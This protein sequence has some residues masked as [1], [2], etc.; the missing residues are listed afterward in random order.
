MALAN[1]AREGMEHAAYEHV[2]LAPEL[3]GPRPH[4][5]APGRNCCQAP[6]AEGIVRADD[7]HGVANVPPRGHLGS[8]ALISAKE[9]RAKWQV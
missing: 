7:P 1:V 9:E 5:F 8:E 2:E 3:L 6:V 4:S